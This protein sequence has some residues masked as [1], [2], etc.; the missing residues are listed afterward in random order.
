[1]HGREKLKSKSTS[2]TKLKVGSQEEKLEKCKEHFK[3]L[4]GNPPEITDNPTKK[5]INSQ[6]GIK[7]SLWRKNMKK[8]KSRSC[9]LQWNTSLMY[10]TQGN[11]TTYFFDY[12]MLCINKTVE[13]EM[14]ANKIQFMYFKQ[15]GTISTLSSRPLKL[16]D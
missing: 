15:E 7:L 9:S 3:N 13:K 8:I 5:I 4:H 12:A 10:G 14:N 6:Q 16:V 1:M 11:L 2:R